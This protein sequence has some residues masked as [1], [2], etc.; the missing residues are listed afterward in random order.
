ML[1][2]CS[3]F[4]ASLAVLLAL[5]A[6]SGSSAYGRDRSVL[7]DFDGD[8]KTDVS[9]YRPGIWTPTVRGTSFFYIRSSLTGEEMAIPF[10]A[11]GDRPAV[12]DYDLDGKADL[13]VF[14]SWED[15][16]KFPWDASDYWIKYSSTGQTEVIYHS[17]YGTVVNRNFVEGPRPELGVFTYRL[18]G[19]PGDPC[20]VEG[21]LLASGINLFQKDVTEDCLGG[22]ITR[23]PALGDYNNDGYSDAATFV[24]NTDA[25]GVSYYE[26]WPSPFI[27]GY[28][29]PPII[30]P[31]N[32]EMIAPGDYDGDGKTDLAG[33]NTK[34]GR[35]RWR[36][37]FSGSGETW[38]LLWGITGDK[39]VPGDYDG[40][41]RTDPAVFRPSTGTWYIFR[42]IDWHWEV[43]QWGLATDIPIP[44]P[45]SF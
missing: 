29:Q 12:A 44:Q 35:Y 26:I 31:F 30:R 10:G 22:W 9:L 36:I 43:Y 28:S 27:A 7:F 4:A 34:E 32:V 40:D 5:F 8:G 41:G 37:E 39:I 11:G 3:T 19:D 1:E 2:R 21:F 14:R 23:V 42:S 16:L 45:N 38:Q 25:R 6:V 20:Y 18:Q 33:A 13:A 15:T 24:R 17:G